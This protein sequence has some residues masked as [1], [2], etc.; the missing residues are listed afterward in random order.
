L[1]VK[2]MPNIKIDGQDYDVDKLPEEARKR[3][4]M[5]AFVDRRIQELQREMMAMQT[6]RN[7][8]AGSLKEVMPAPAAA[9]PAGLP[10]GD[11]IRFNTPG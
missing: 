9:A 5:L 3:L 8:Y 11:T 1:K 2:T 4:E 6:A 7:A 10:P